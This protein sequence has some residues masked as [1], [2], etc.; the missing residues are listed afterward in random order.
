M[1]KV[2]LSEK[3]QLITDLWSP[4]AVGAVN[5]FLVKLVKLKGGFVWHA[6]EVED[7][8]FLVLKGKLRMQFRDGEV[9]VEPGEFIIVPRRTEHRPVADEEVQVLLFEPGST[10]NTGTAGGPRTREVEWI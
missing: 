7:E 3:L 10:V 8:L 5:D 6:H 2:N 4:K 9:T 1:E